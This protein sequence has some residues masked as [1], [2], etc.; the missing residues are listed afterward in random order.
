MELKTSVY[1][2]E[3]MMFCNQ[4]QSIST[5]LVFRILKVSRIYYFV[6]EEGDIDLS[7]S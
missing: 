5:V 6:L 3:V 2:Y 4:I 1:P 7:Q